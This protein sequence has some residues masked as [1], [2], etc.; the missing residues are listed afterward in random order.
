MNPAHS[1]RW[2]TNRRMSGVKKNM[3]IAAIIT[4]RG[5]SSG[6]PRKNL[7]L[8]MGKPLITY[9]IR[10]ALGCP[11]I[12]RCFVTTEDAEIK[13]VSLAEGAEVIDRPKRLATDNALSTDTVRHALKYLARQDYHP[14]YFVLLQPTSPL[15]DAQ[16]LTSCL[17]KFFRSKA[18]CA[19]SFTDVKHHPY[20]C[21]KLDRK[22]ITP[23]KNEKEM[24]RPR[25]LLPE[26]YAQN[27]AIYAMPT[28]T[29]LKNDAFYV[30]PVMPFFMSTEDSIDIDNEV[31]LKLAE[32]FALSKTRKENKTWNL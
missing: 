14:E 20:K 29:F 12:E 10:A 19:I 11:F 6:V 2:G 23:L 24:E 30:H 8:L 5:G 4:A 7:R 16:H 31:D 21:F 28:K 9:S 3:P 15:R 25:Q 1:S 18:N 13:A 32:F 22:K 26:I 27:G 17:R